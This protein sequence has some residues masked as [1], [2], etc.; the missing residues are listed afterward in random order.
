MLYELQKR[1]CGK[2]KQCCSLSIS[3]FVGL[4]YPFLDKRLDGPLIYKGEWSNVMRC[5]AV[6]VGINH[7]SA[8][9]FEK[10]FNMIMLYAFNRDPSLFVFDYLSNTITVQPVLM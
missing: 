1:L 10:S 3:A 6:F 9:S 5:V 7:A 2:L 4:L 8:V